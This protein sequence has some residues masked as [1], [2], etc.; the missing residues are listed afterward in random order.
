[1]KILTLTWLSPHLIRCS[2]EDDGQRYDM[3][4]ELFAEG[5]VRG[6]QLLDLPRDEKQRLYNAR[7]G[8]ELTQVLW[9][10][11]D[12]KT[13]TLPLDLKTHVNS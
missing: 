5:A 9:Q 10:Y 7:E 12:G 1:M 11:V 3:T 6:L 13:L 2:F 8:L 4:V